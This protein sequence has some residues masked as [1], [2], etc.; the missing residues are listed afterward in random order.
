MT[1]KDSLWLK[2]DAGSLP[3]R[4]FFKNGRDQP[5]CAEMSWGGGREETA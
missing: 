2:D 5:L 1:A 3:G 4:Q